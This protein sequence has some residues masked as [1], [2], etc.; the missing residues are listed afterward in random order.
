[1]WLIVVVPFMLGM[2]VAAGQVDWSALERGSG[3]LM[4][5]VEAAG[6]APAL[7]FAAL[8][9]GWSVL[10]LALLYP[11]F[12][13]MV[14][15]WWI[16]GLRFGEL[17]VASHL[18]TRTVYAIYLRFMWIALIAGVVFA[19][20]AAVALAITGGLSLW[21]GK[22]ALTE[23]ISTAILIG[24]LCRRCARLFDHLPG[25]REN[26][27]LEGCFRVD[28]AVRSRCARSGECLGR[29]GLSGRRG[30]CRR[31]QCRR[32]LSMATAG[33]GIFFDGVTSARRPVLVELSSEGLV[34]RDAE[35]RAMLAR[36]PYNE[37]DHLAAPDGMLR[38]GRAGAPRLARLEV[39]EPAL[40]AAI[41]DASVPVDRSGAAERRSRVKVV[42][43]SVI[44]TVSLLLGAVY[45]VPALADKIAPLIPLRAERWLGEAVDTRRARCSIRATPVARSNV[46]TRTDARRSRN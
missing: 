21:L 29:R 18:H 17:T 43:W 40:I 13:A 36:W 26:P 28:R 38:L 16:S 2:L 8:S 7:V 1:L 20:A 32:D 44:A 23:L 19:I 46:R 31:A 24:L 14:L 3:D 35:E 30:T 37:L 15:R 4:S 10:A 9:I 25:D 34:V 41:D 22:G 27:P 12:Q 6:I 45:G 42:V 33:T 5:R 39:R 11:V